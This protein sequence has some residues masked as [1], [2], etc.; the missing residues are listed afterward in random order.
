MSNAF[1]ALDRQWR[2]IHVNDGAERIVRRSREELLGRTIWEVFPT[3]LGTKV[4]TV[5]RR[6]MEQGATVNF[7]EYS[8]TL[9]AWF[10]GVVCPASDGLTIEARDITERKLAEQKL[11]ERERFMHQ[12]AEL[13]P[14]V[15]TVVDLVTGRHSYIS[16]DV[17]NLH[18]YTLNEIA[19]ITDV[20][21]DLLHPDDVLR[22]RE[23][24]E[25]LRQLADGQI[26]LIEYRIRHRD[27]TSRWLVSRNMAFARDDAGNVCQVVSATIDITERKEAELALRRSEERLRLLIESAEDYAIVTL[28]MQ[29]RL[30]SWSRGAERLF[31]YTEHEVIGQCE[32]IL[33]S[34]EDRGRGVSSEAMRQA[35]NHGRA[36]DERYYVRK[37][38]TRFFGSGVMTVLQD[39][40]RGYARITRDLT[41]R[42]R[43][44][45]ALLHAN[46]RLE[47]RVVER[48]RQLSAVNAELLKQIND[49]LQM[50]GKLRRSEAYLAEG[51]R[52]SHVG[53]GSWNVITGEVFWSD[54]TCRIYGFEPGTVTPSGELFFRTVVHPEDRRNLEEAFDRVVRDRSGYELEFRIVRPDGT[55]RHIHSVGH[56][57]LNEAGDLSEVIGTVM[58]MSERIRANGNL[59]KTQAALAH[60][61]RVVTLGELTASIAHEVNQ[62]LGAVVT[63]AQACARWLAMEPANLSE[64]ND[65]MQRIVRDAHRASSVISRIRAFVKR[66]EQ[67]RT[68]FNVNDVINEA[69]SLVQVEASMQG[70][71]FHV[72]AGAGLPHV[73]ADR[74]ELQQVILNLVVNG[75]E[76]MT[77]IRRQP[78]VLAL[79]TA[80]YGSDAILVSV[81]DSGAG[82][83][84]HTRD[85]I[86]D[87]F[88]TTKPDGMGMGLAISRS[89]VEAHGGRIWA[90]PNGGPGE[91]L[92]FTLPIAASAT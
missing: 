8:T 75:I 46:E 2:Y 67:P 51:Q 32:E 60:V 14:V 55:V 72:E 69:L 81:R 43:A 9:N 21:F 68:L 15:I 42:Q 85:G 50:E 76:A 18:G 53:S 73:L 59:A 66:T 39:G 24:F 45:E 61:T 92:Q 89:I 22:V 19:G 65:A 47:A 20:N 56:P 28:D 77:S 82:L 87:A 64:A 83:E 3:L 40:T 62:P 86:F 48:T 58:D 31:G 63:S 70:V 54:E 5:C 10:E 11:R 71:S 30:S 27:S 17:V 16:R 23:N 6:A 38:G 78:K 44:A 52:L 80:C 29:G 49:R 12:V 35:Q 88:F 1:L 25:L 26:N 37:N 90:T 84:P 7:E 74:V 41:E 91:T 4:E 33:F 79:A 13:T 36:A 57:L 34:P